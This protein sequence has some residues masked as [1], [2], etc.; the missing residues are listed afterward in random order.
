ME[1]TI[2]MKSATYAQCRIE[3]HQFA[4]I[5]DTGAAGCI[6]SKAALDRLGW[7]IEASTNQT[8][9]VADGRTTVPLGKVFELP[10]QFGKI[11]IPITAMVVEATSYDILIGNDWLTKA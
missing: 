8:M 10:I 9:S 5:I 11:I 1:M 7:V 2:S 4:V 3:E 6:A